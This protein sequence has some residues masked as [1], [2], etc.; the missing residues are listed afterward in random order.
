MLNVGRASGAMFRI[1][2]CAITASL[3]AFAQVG[4]I[5]RFEEYPVTKVFQGTPAPPILVTPEERLYRTRIRNGVRDGEGV[6]RENGVEGIPRPNFAGHYIVVTWEC[7]S[8]CNEMAIVDAVTG[9]VYKP[10][11]SETH[12]LPLLDGAPCFPGV[13]FHLDSKLMIM[14]PTPNM[15][16][17]PIYIHYFLWENNKW[18]LIR[19]IPCGPKGTPTA[20][21]K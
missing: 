8:P 2:F 14:T 4:A 6:W 16:R 18:T 10:P 20:C 3:T 7:G 15:A 13:E 19:R 12:L 21:E 17:V 1:H 5:P 11:M 9:K